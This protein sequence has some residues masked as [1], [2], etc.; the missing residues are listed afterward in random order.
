MY[1]LRETGHCGPV[2]KKSKKS[3]VDDGVGCGPHKTIAGR[4]YPT[5]RTA[6]SRQP[7][8][9]LGAPFYGRKKVKNTVDFVIRY[10]HCPR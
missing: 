8:T 7:G 2:V 9:E 10:S 5:R 1:R 4:T 6:I 3:S